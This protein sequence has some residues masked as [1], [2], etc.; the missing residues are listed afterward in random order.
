MMI[1]DISSAKLK[2]Y[3]LAA[4]SYVPSLNLDF[5]TDMVIQICKSADDDEDVYR[6]LFDVFSRH[7]PYMKRKALNDFC[8]I[9]NLP[10][11]TFSA[12]KLSSD[13]FLRCLNGIEIDLTPLRQA[14]PMITAMV[15][16]RAGSSQQEK[17]A[18]LAAL[19]G[20]KHLENY[21]YESLPK[22]RELFV[23]SADFWEQWC[24]S[25]NWDDE[26]DFGLKIE[27]S[28][29]IRNAELLEPGH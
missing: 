6:Y 13:A 4:V 3:M 2:K 25:V 24:A 26:T 5:V 19:N 23:V 1:K 12:Q 11:T 16:L 18:I 9:F 15:G 29:S 20:N 22:E 7:T 21:I 17:Q 27:R 14:N 8:E 10:K 28:L